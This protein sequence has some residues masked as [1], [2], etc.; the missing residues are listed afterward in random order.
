MWKMAAGSNALAFAVLLIVTYS[1]MD[2]CERVLTDLSWIV[3]SGLCCSKN[4]VISS[5]LLITAWC[6]L[7]L[8]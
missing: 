1:A 8:P 3:M 7:A 2:M 4:L 6:K 5:D